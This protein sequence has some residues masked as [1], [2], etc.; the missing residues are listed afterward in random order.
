MYISVR[1]TAKTTDATPHACSLIP[2]AYAMGCITKVVCSQFALSWGSRGG[3]KQICRIC[4]FKSQ[5]LDTAAREKGTGGR[6]NY[7]SLLRLSEGLVATD[8]QL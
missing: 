6:S 7:P 2:L 3:M 4:A 1:V 5:H 8:D